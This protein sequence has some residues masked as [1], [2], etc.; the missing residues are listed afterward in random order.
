MCYIM[1]LCV[2]ASYV[3]VLCVV[4]RDYDRRYVLP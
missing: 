2:V 1:V 3:V 4:L